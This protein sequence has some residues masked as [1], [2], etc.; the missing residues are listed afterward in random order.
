MLQGGECA[1]E[2]GA[3]SAA[4]ASVGGILEIGIVAD[5]SESGDDH[6]SKRAQR[7]A[8]ADDDLVS[9]R[10]ADSNDVPERLD[11]EFGL[12][13]LGMHMLGSF[14]WSLHVTLSAFT[15]GNA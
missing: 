6:G 13:K 3:C 4:P 7:G 10:P 5:F 8:M 15:Q 9:R 14:V 12:A 2:P 11:A 1:S